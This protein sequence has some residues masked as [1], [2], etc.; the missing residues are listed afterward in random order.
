M[1]SNTA[2]AIEEYLYVR[3]KNHKEISDPKTKQILNK[4]TKDIY[5]ICLPRDI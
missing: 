1:R 2:K 4:I 5:K 3:V